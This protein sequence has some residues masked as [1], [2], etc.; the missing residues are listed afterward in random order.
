MCGITGFINLKN[1][2]NAAALNATVSRMSDAFIHRGPDGSGAWCDEESGIA[3]GHRRLAIIDLTAAGH[4]PMASSNDRYVI[5]YNGE[6]YNFPALK[7]RLEAKGKT[8]NG[9]SDTEVLLSAIE[10]WGLTETLKEINGMFAFALWDKHNKT[11]HLARDRMGEKPLYYGWSGDVF[12]FGSELKSLR[13]HPDFR[14]D[15]DRQ[16]L[17]LYMRHSYIPAPLSIY[18]GIHKLPPASFLTIPL[19]GAKNTQPTLYWN[20]KDIAEKGTHNPL[21][22]SFEQAVDELDTRLYDAVQSRMLSDVP[23]GS[24]LSGGIDSSL[25][26]A[27]MQKGSTNTVKTFCIGFEEAAYNEAQHAKEIA[28]HL[29]TNHTQ[30]YV[31]AQEARNI[32]P[33]LPTIYDEPFADPS[34]I[35]TYMV[36]KLARQHVTVALSGDGGDE[37]FAGYSRYHLTQKINNVLGPVPHS[38]RCAMAGIL[39]KLPIGG[40]AQKLLQIMDF[41]TPEDLYALIMAQ[42]KDSNIV[43][44]NKTSPLIATNDTIAHADLPHLVDHMTYT[45]MCSYLP[46]AIMVKVDRASM[47]ASLETRAPLLDHTLIEFAWALPRTM[48]F[49]HGE[50]KRILRTLL[51]RYIPKPLFDRPKQG[52]GIPHGQW[53][54]G[55]LREWAETLIEPK[56]LK[57]EGFLNPELIHQKWQEHLSGK[58]DWSYFIWNVLM[59]QAWYEAQ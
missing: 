17:S 18:K 8:F 24:F 11:M 59:F 37:G 43:L 12:L 9:T 27:L 45:D 36:A 40:R 32:I 52:F 41:K 31:T 10:E 7:Q 21:E 51:E 42:W 14:A 22:I 29:G 35:P 44:E 5:T 38:L 2:Q 48:K 54:R 50:G 13:A 33:S 23:L 55:P 16:A 19:K 15:I 39:T 46:D 20:L 53:L 4:Q 3:L 47:A 26:T 28:N 30:F 1:D 49:N 6:I 25:I 56:R 34:Q 57:E 58:Q